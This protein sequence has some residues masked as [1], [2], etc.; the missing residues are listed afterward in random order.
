MMPSAP[1]EAPRGTR[2]SQ[3]SIGK[4]PSA[5]MTLSSLLPALTTA[6]AVAIFVL[7]S[8]TK[9]NVTIAVLYVVAVMMSASFCVRREVLA[10]SGACMVLTMVSFVVMRGKHYNDTSVGQ[11]RR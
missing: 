1:Q 8:L 10:V 9:I 11:R 7:D 3:M 6:F 5:S 4:P 2:A